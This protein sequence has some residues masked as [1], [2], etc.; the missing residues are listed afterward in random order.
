MHNLRANRPYKSHPY[1][2]PY[3]T[4]E[5]KYVRKYLKLRKDDCEALFVSLKGP[6]ARLKQRHTQYIVED[7]VKYLI[8]QA[9]LPLGTLISPHTLR[10]AYAT[11][12]ISSG[13]NLAA[14]KELMGHS[15]I[16]TTQ[17]YLHLSNA[18]LKTEYNK[19]YK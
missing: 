6:I 3:K 15:S 18:D 13:A 1:T 14:V 5:K 12:L 4:Y 9:K 19:V 16:T 2:R 11:H 8:E 10:H 17:R 7:R